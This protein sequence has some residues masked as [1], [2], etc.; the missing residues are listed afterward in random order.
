MISKYIC[1]WIQQLFY[2]WLIFGY[3]LNNKIILTYIN[4][5]YLVIFQIFAQL[6]LYSYLI[7][8]K[9]FKYDKDNDN[10]S[11]HL[12]NLLFHILPLIIMINI[13]KTQTKYAFETMIIL[14]LSYIIYMKLINQ[15][16]YELY[17]ENNIVQSW[18]EMKKIC[19]KNKNSKDLNCLIVNMFKR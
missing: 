15:S 18:D 1:N 4:P 17:F 7:Y 19:L 10:Y 13:Q 11:Y 8:S 2:F 14:I 9:K 5:Y 3:Y 16:I 6:F 12:S